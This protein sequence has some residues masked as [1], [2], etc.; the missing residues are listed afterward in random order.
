MPYVPTGSPQKS[1]S[2]VGIQDVFHSTNVFVNNVPVALWQTPGNSAAFSAD[3]SVDQ[4][5]VDPIIVAAIQA[6][7]AA[8]LS[9]PRAFAMPAESVAQGAI[10]PE[11]QGTPDAIT[12]ATGTIS[13]PTVSGIIPFLATTLEEAGRGM[14]NRTYQD[15][16]VDNT[17]I[18][19]IWKSLGLGSVFQH[20][21]TAWCMGFVN[22]ALK[23]AGYKWCP[24]AGAISIKN[25]PTR[26]D[27]TE[28]A[29]DQ[30][31]PGDIALWD[32][33]GHNHVCFVYTADNG[34]YTFVGGNQNG[35]SPTNNNPSSSTVSK[36]W[37]GGWTIEHN[38]P[39]STLVGLWRPSNA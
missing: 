5:T 14:W 33:G 9:N 24:E 12:T 30:G 32:Y 19:G 10:Q 34:K 3:V 4:V 17:N 8:F 39:G 1:T 36:S 23:Q 25:N 38:K 21:T 2:N 20:D 18:M 22:F 26:W 29:L 27:A 37:P 11:Y 16:G 31:Q 7:D 28:I 35:K 6:K 13:A 15:T